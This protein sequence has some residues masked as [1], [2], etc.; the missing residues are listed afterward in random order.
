VNK[1]EDEI[2]KTEQIIDYL[3]EER[4][5]VLDNISIIEIANAIDTVEN[6]CTDVNRKMRDGLIIKSNSNLPEECNRFFHYLS[7]K[8]RG[9]ITK[10][11]KKEDEMAL[12]AQRSLIAMSIKS[13]QKSLDTATDIQHINVLQHS[14]DAYQKQLG[15]TMCKD[16]SLKR[17]RLGFLMKKR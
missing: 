10:S 6:E 8:D 4:E 14:L 5:R 15:D 13:T 12:D 1:L 11:E 7:M 2:Y 9:I 16:V 3:K 17:N